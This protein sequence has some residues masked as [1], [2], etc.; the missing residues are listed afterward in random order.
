MTTIDRRWWSPPFGERPWH[1]TIPTNANKFLRPSGEG[2]L[3]TRSHRVLCPSHYIIETYEMFSWKPHVVASLLLFSACRST[4]AMHNARQIT[5]VPVKIRFLR[6]SLLLSLF[7]SLLFVTLSLSRFYSG[8]VLRFG[9]RDRPSTATVHRVTANCSCIF[10]YR[11]SPICGFSVFTGRHEG[12]KEEK[13][14]S[15]HYFAFYR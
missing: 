6:S 15:R 11:R 3:G 1:L 14:G 12:A 10:G 9:N 5:A 4:I 7:L 2:G 13:P 8:P